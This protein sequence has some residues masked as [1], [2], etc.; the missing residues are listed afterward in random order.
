MPRARSGGATSDRRRNN[1][2]AFKVPCVLHRAA[3]AHRLPESD[4]STMTTRDLIDTVGDRTGRYGH[5][6]RAAVGSAGLPTHLA[7]IRGSDRSVTVSNGVEM[8]RVSF[9]LR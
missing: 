8:T 3:P 5:G 1:H 2:H 9:E 7:S 4:K 6:T